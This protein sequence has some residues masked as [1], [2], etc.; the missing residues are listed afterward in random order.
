MTKRVRLKDVAAAAGVS[1]GTASNVFNK[2]DLVTPQMRAAVE[3]AAERLGYRGPQAA[4]RLL[5]SGKAGLVALLTDESAAELVQNSYGRR[6]LAGAA[7]GCDAAGVGLSIVGR[8]AADGAAGWSVDT[9]IADGFVLYCFEGE[10]D[11]AGRIA[12]RGLPF[13]TIDGPRGAGLGTVGVDDEGAAE[14]VMAHLTGLG[15]RRIGALSLEVSR[16]ADPGP[17]T[18]PFGARYRT[19][20]LRLAGYARAHAAAG[21]APADFLPFHTLS[22]ERS[23]AMGLAWLFDR[24][25]PPTAIAAMSDAIAMMA[26]AE[27]RARGLS[28]PDDVSVAGFDGVT[29]GAYADPPLTTVIQPAEDKGL[30]ALEMLLG[31]RPPADLILPTELIVRAS[32]AAPRRMS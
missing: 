30:A 10:D 26:M 15:H 23:V 7:Q 27:L 19:P 16:N 1:Q 20:G 9:A 18:G 3:A 24:P 13:V 14:S 21:N 28:V 5:R 25:D 29:E 17:L 2:P 4:A 11:I 8:T 12:R 32:T 22:D 31:T 6:I